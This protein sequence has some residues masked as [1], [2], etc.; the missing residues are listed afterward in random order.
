MEPL[1]VVID[2]I[3]NIF[4][5][6]NYWGYSLS[7]Y[8][9]AFYNIHPNYAGYLDDKKTLTF[10]KINEIFGMI[11]D[12]KKFYFD[13]EYIETLYLQYMSRE[14]AENKGIVEFREK[15]KGKKVLLIAPGASAEKEKDKLQAFATQED[16]VTISVNFAYPHID[17]E[18]IFVS[19]LRRFQMLDKS[20][21]EK[22]IVTSNLSAEGMFLEVEYK[23]LLNDFEMVRD[24][25]GLMAI[26]FLIDCEVDEIYLA[27]FDGYSH[28]Y[29]KN[30][31]DAK[32]A[33][34]IRNEA[35]DAMNK[36]V[37]L[38]LKEF[39]KNVKISYLTERRH[40]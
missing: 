15:V 24:N 7:N 4:Y 32:M 13:K 40:K 26:K 5:K 35:L 23:D 14:M 18:Y 31:G 20:K 10:E 27:G 16:V 28:D 30:Y 38:A 11:D 2:E 21:K 1:L 33:F 3:L 22:C 29:Q 6:E 36:G 37:S 8:L 17:T 12:N 19:N 34:V 39:S 9:S 25:A